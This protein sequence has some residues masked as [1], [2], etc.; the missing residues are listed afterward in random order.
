ML[1]VHVH[2]WYQTCS[3]WILEIS[4]LW[5]EGWESE[6]V[7]Q[8]QEI[9]LRKSACVCIIFGICYIPWTRVI[10]ILCKV[11]HVEFISRPALVLLYIL[12]VRCLLNN[13]LAYM[14]LDELQNVDIGSWMYAMGNE[15][16]CESIYIVKGLYCLVLWI[17]ILFNS[18]KS[19]MFIANQSFDYTRY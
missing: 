2:Y 4:F 19:I 18:T 9:T 17:K 6:L 16:S 8:D 5:L 15:C 14:Y 11:S 12:F 13:Y 7:I 3:P 10:F 1:H